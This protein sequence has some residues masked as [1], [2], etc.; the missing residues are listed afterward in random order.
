M[1]RK[2]LTD[3]AATATHRSMETAA[4]RLNRRR[5]T[6]GLYYARWS[7]K[8]VRQAGKLAF[9]SARMFGKPIPRRPD[10]RLGVFV[11]R[12]PPDRLFRMRR[13]GKKRNGVAGSARTI[14]DGGFFA[15]HFFG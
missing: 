6:K 2:L 15:G 5:I 12:F 9:V 3:S 10:D 14:C 1:V 11:F 4:S 8:N 13:I 7:K